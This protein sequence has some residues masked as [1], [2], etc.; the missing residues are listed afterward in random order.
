MDKMQPRLPFALCA[1][2]LPHN[3]GYLPTRSGEYIRQPITP[4]GLIERAIQFGLAGVEFPLLSR[5]P[6]FDGGKVETQSFAGNLGETLGQH[7]LGFVA[8]YGALMDYEAKH[9]RDYLELAAE[10][11]ARVVRCILSHLLCGDRR[12]IQGGWMA[13]RISLAERL[14]E[15]LP[16]AESLDI[17]LAVENHQDASSDDLL[18][19]YA[20]TGSS[21]A[22]GVTLDTGNPLAV[23]EDPVKY[24][25]R[26]AHIIRHVHLKD[27]TMHFAPEGFRLV[28]CAA[29][30]G[31]VD[32]REI[33]AILST[34][35]HTLLPA[36]EIAAQATRTVPMLEQDW[37]N[38]YPGQQATHL[39]GALKSLWEYGRPQTE[40]YSTRWELGGA[41][42]EVA[43]EEWELVNASI[44]YFRTI[45]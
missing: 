37:W 40:P 21:P 43:A 42:A 5:A 20:E 19:L 28:R 29:G 13:H 1:Y 15:L 30:A 24:T 14:R 33:L 4:N 32:F 9:T 35:G 8:D 16:V 2:S 11:G 22:F 25:Q 18:E 38:C 3:M 27:Y 17:A 6:V 26:I 12:D 23:C 41:S 10:S 44:E 45:V 31:V 7:N 39:P 36:I 34:N